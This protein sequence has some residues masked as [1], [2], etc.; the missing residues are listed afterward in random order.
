MK[1][2]FC[3]SILLLFISLFISS[4]VLAQDVNT[5]NIRTGIINY[6]NEQ[7]TASELN[8]MLDA[9]AVDKASQD[10]ADYCLATKQATS[11]QK[12]LKKSN[13][14][15]RI[16]FY[17]GIKNGIP[18]EIVLSEATNAKGK[19]LS[20]SLILERCI[21]NLNKSTYRKMFLRPDLY[22]LGA[23]LSYDTQTNKVYLCLVMGDIN[24]IN[25]T[26][27]HQ[28][29]LD[30]KYRAKSF[31]MHWLVRRIK[32]KIFC[33]FGEC[34]DGTVC[35]QYDDLKE[36]YSKV[37][38]DKGFYIKENRL[39][40][41]EDFKKYFINTEK[42][43]R[44]LIE[45][46]NDRLLISIIEL[47]QF[48][49]NTSYNISA[50]GLMQNGL[51]IGL[52]PITL[53][54]LSRK[55]DLMID[56]LPKGFA[57]NFEISI[58]AVKYC[59]EKVKC[60][61]WSF[62]DKLVRLKAN[63]KPV[64]YTDL[65]LI[66]DT[67]ATRLVEPYMEYK[68]LSFRIPFE[69][70]KFDFRTQ[71][72]SPFIDSM[73]EPKFTIQ[74]IEITGY[75][76]ME[77]D[78]AKNV[79][80]QNKR[81]AS[82]VKV[83]E[84]QQSGS[85]I[86][87]NVKTGNTWDIFKK[88]ILLTNWYYLADSTP[89]QVNLRLN[90]DTFLIHRIEKLLVDE[91]FATIQMKVA[92]D[93]K[94]M[95]EDEYWVYRFNKAIEKKDIK[96]ALTDQAAMMSLLK[97]GLMSNN[98]FQAL[99]IPYEPKYIMLLN[100]KAVFIQDENQRINKF[101][102]LLKLAP[103]NPYVKFNYLA[104]KLNA[105]ADLPEDKRREELQILA[106]LYGSLN[107]THIPADVKST[108]NSRFYTVTHDLKRFKKTETYNS[109]KALSKSSPL[110]ESITLADY[111]A[112]LR[113]F[114]I[115]AQILLD[116]LSILDVNDK[117]L[118]KE[119]CLRVLYYGKVSGIPEFEKEYLQIFRLLQKTNPDIFCELFNQSK[120]SFKF[121]ENLHIKKMYCDKCQQK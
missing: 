27:A 70:N 60:E 95:N 1:K 14:S 75:S 65:P 106:S 43:V 35:G 108:I 109:V 33:W 94:K 93:L 22:Y 59:N 103:D 39:Y 73:N 68:Q 42:N 67:Q 98:M 47:S 19:A 37:D 55:G 34:D 5:D 50:G 38:I 120:V 18:L 107:T 58:S 81:A 44:T 63:I 115:A 102:E 16:T 83:L 119:F 46:G 76:S 6:I 36:I 66:I 12:E 52:R 32:C 113:H 54:Q 56:K 91:R 92:F 74:N 23:G 13:A 82:I 78:S 40:L 114:D 104:L 85:K 99:N 53:K 51:E 30:K 96:R 49:C 10:Q 25:N 101:E 21:K 48:P 71:D 62:Y 80:L 57:N 3:K 26:A 2:F 41:K 79:D 7:R 116:H 31:A 86:K 11:V 100:N 90:R 84:Q 45:D 121:F 112:D 9:D 117:P 64:V 69:K 77:G 87:Y 17:G 89:K 97:E 105:S 29:E 88:Q 20:D 28:K 72:I 111:Y 4:F 8:V 118:C 15:L 61:A 110:L 24:I